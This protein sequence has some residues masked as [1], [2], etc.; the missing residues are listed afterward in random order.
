MNNFIDEPAAK[1]VKISEEA[2]RSFE[3][4][5]IL[6]KEVIV[7]DDDEPAVPAAPLRQA[8]GTTEE[9]IRALQLQMENE[10]DDEEDENATYVYDDDEYDD[11]YD[12]N[13]DYD[14]ESD[15]EEDPDAMG[16][17]EVYYDQNE[18]FQSLVKPEDGDVVSVAA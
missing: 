7:I 9:F 8:R 14:E 12:D 2:P 6:I 13:V 15:E 3:D 17:P 5:V 18:F 10:G 4:E 1:R 16:E 11:E